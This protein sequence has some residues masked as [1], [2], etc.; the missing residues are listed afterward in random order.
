MDTV[1]VLLFVELT[2]PSYEVFLQGFFTIFCR[3]YKLRN[4]VDWKRLPR[5]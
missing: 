4:L 3:L 5:M 2:V 1:K